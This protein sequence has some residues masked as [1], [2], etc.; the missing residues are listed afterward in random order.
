MTTLVGFDLDLTLVDSASGITATFVQACAEVGVT[1][2]GAD[3]KPL[4]G[5]PLRDNAVRLVGEPQADEVARIYKEIFPAIALPLITL[6][7]GATETIAAVKRGGGKAIVVSARTESSAHEIVDKV[8]LELDEVLGDRYAELK[9][10]ALAARGADVFV[11]DHP[12]DMVGARAG[13]AFAVGVATG[14]HD[15]EQLRS[16]GANVILDNLVDFPAWF[17]NFTSPNGS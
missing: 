1:I 3:V 2:N 15:A 13:G 4:I 5:L 17:A 16:A 11:G 6:M 10:E 7:P 9:G 14:T 12:G 8:G